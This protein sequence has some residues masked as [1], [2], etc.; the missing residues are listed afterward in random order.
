MKKK[1][2][3]W[4]TIS[5]K[6]MKFHSDVVQGKITIKNSIDLWTFNWLDEHYNPPTKK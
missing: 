4:K 1:K 5:K 6:Y 2:D 3:S